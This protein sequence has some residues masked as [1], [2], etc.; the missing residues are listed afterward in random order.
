MLIPGKL[1]EIYKLG[2]GHEANIRI[3]DISVSRFHASIKS[4][5]NGFVI[6]DNNAKFGTLVYVKNKSIIISNSSS[7]LQVGR[8]KIVVSLRDIES[9]S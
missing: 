6:K 8:T 5:R 2:R 7:V 9:P 4:T 1:D 3:N